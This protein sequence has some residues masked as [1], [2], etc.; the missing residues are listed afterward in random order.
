MRLAIV[1]NILPPYR[2]PL[3]NRI[4]AEEGLTLKVFLCA[5]TEPNRQWEWPENVRFDYD[6]GSTLTWSPMKEKTIYFN[7]GI[8]RRLRSF[9]PDVIITGSIG[10]VSLMSW[11]AARKKKIPVILWTEGM[12]GADGI[13]GKIARPLRRFLVRK[14]AACIASSSSAVEMFRYYGASKDQVV[15]SMI[16]PDIE[17]FRE[18]V[19]IAT[20]EKESLKRAMELSGPVVLYVGQI[21]TR[22]GVDFLLKTFELVLGTIP[23]A[24]LLIVGSGS[25]GKQYQRDMSPELRSRVTWCGFIQQEELPAYY[26]VADVFALFSLQEPFGLVVTEALAASLPVV[27]SKFTGASYDLVEQGRNG[28]IIHPKEIKENAARFITLLTD[29]A[30]R[31]TMSFHSENILEKCSVENAAMSMIGCA[32]MACS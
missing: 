28:Y 14:A 8:I 7:P 27:C 4:A 20:K 21:E 18:K 23:D 16:C 11:V 1:T 25:K 24:N 10:I 22:K 2:V 3:F 19:K 15:L 32:A 30:L 17:P 31:A 5:E 13:L 26:A 6:V 9:D 29:D 12:L